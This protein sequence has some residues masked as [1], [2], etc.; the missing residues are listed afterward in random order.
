MHR[1]ICIQALNMRTHLI[2]AF[3]LAVSLAF[4]L[5]TAAAQSGKAEPAGGGKANRR[6]AATPTP[7]STPGP[8]I[9]DKPL[10]V[11][12]ANDKS[13]DDGEV[14]RVN[15]ELVSIPVRVMDKSGRFI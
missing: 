10:P 9:L 3:L 5:T 13:G 1:R 12:P 2:S 14:I 15:T 11:T 6:P 7:V 4:G 8:E